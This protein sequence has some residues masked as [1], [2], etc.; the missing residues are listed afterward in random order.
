MIPILQKEIDEFVEVWNTHKIRRQKDVVLPCGRPNHIYDFPEEY[1]LEQCGVPIQEDTILTAISH[2]AAG[3]MAIQ[4]H[5]S[6]LK[7]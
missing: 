6:D 7:T 2:S 4:K 1:N 3:H 5:S